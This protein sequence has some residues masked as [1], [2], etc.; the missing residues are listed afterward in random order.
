[1][2]P[3]KLRLVRVTIK[4]FL[5]FQVVVKVLVTVIIY[6]LFMWDSHCQDGLWESLD[7]W[8]YYIR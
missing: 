3:K 6:G 5:I 1:M 7:D 8:V 4:D 2:E